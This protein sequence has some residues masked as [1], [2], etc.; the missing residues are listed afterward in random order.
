MIIHFYEYKSLALYFWLLF[1]ENVPENF[2]QLSHSFTFYF[3]QT[4]SAEYE[5]ASNGLCMILG[6]M[7]HISI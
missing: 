4:K 7:E 2:M 1:Y 5:K 3:V 6:I